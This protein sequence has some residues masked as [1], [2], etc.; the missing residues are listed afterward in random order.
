MLSYC[1]KLDSFLQERPN[2]TTP[3]HGYFCNGSDFSKLKMADATILHFATS[4]LM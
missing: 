1:I 2:E 3:F 4:F